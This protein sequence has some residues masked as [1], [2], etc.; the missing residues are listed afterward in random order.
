MKKVI[1]VHLLNDYSGS[2]KVL[3][4]V[5]KVAQEKG[6]DVELYT[7][8]G[9]GFL[10]NITKN[11]HTYIYKRFENKYLTLLS[12]IVS[13]VHLF[14]K[15]LKYRNQDVLV[16]INTMLPFGAALAA[17]LM[18]K[19]VVYHIHETNLTPY[20]FKQFLRKIIELT[21]FKNIFVSKYVAESEGFEKI[22]GIV[23]YNA[24]PRDFSEK[25]DEHEYVVQQD[26]FCVLMVCSMK[27]YKGIGEFLAIADLCKG[28]TR[29]SFTLILNENQHTI[30]SYF[31]NVTIPVN[32]NILTRKE[33]LIPYYQKANLLLNLSR[34]DQW[35]E[36]FGLTILE[37]MAFG[38]PV[39]VPP[40]GGPVEIV[41]QNI[42]GYLISSYEVNKVAEKVCLLAE[43]K[44]ICMELSKAAKLRVGTFGFRQFEQKIME[45]IESSLSA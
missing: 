9:K 38:V 16:Y 31:Q 3:S 23:V 34:V 42:E 10:S 43:N 1:F 15:L 30:D 22:E 37:A 14:L 40:V 13:Q 2:P 4:Q 18:N 17:R 27:A 45:A 36:T 33:D 5:I 11:H 41:R 19:K 44:N 20:L 29:V 12:F 35:V 6:V 25:A 26:C 24:L 28:N 32:V 39:I 21:A 8:K 7:S